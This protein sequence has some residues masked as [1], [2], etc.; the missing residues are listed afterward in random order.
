MVLVEHILCPAV[1]VSVC[2]H[3]FAKL[4]KNAL[5]SPT[6]FWHVEFYDDWA[7]CVLPKLF[8]LLILQFHLHSLYY[9]RARLSACKQYE[10]EAKE[11]NFIS[12]GLSRICLH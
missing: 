6:C 4:K 1:H 10:R 9:I 3:A 12:Y 8:S 11:R 5:S 7:V 2:L